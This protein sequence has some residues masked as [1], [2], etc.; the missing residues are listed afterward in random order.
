MIVPEPT[1]R[2][3]PWYL[4][5][6]KILRGRGRTCV[7]STYIGKELHLEPSV[8]AKDLSYL[9]IKGKTRIGYDIA[10]LEKEL[11][12][13]LG[14]DIRHNAVVIGV[15]SLGEALISD[16]G[17]INYGLEI[18]AGFDIRPEIIGRTLNSIPVFDIGDLKEEC[19]RLNVEIAVI[20][21]PVN[22]AEEVTSLAVKSN[23]RA[24][25]NFTPLRL[26]VP[27]HVVIQNTSIY[28][29]LAIIYNR[30]KDFDTN[31]CII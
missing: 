10:S 9:N 7:S 21:V 12:D 29:P 13:F 3:L 20:T 5:L 19:E 16:R 28:A 15:G 30:L 18:V 31:S 22:A 14:Y 11:H 23:I 17:L 24:I 1:L 25:W 6:L 26:K 8:I 27:Q 4:S 2:R